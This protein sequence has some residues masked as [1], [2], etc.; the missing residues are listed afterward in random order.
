MEYFDVLDENGNKTGKT[1]LRNS[2]HRDGDWH[3][4]VHVWILNDKKELLLQ[5]RSP[6]KDSSPNKWDISSAGHLSAGDD[7]LTGALREIEEEL[8]IIVAKENL[9]FLATIKKST[10]HS[11]IFINNEFND[12]YILNLNIEL[13]QI[14]IQEEEVSDVKFIYYKNLEKMVNDKIENLIIHKEEY[15]IL[16]KLLNDKFGS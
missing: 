14:K 10:K 16:F 6:N 9:E 2:V 5:K 7:S 12:V 1:K 3:K 11:K 15:E 8:G 4:A 13:S